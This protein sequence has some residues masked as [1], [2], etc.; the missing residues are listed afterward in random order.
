MSITKK[1]ILSFLI[2]I[3]SFS[4][5]FVASPPLIEVQAQD[6]I[7]TQEGMSEIRSTYGGKNPDDIRIIAVKMIILVL[8]FLGILVLVLILFAGFQWMTSAGNEEKI[9]K[10]KKLLINALI[11]L[12]IILVSWTIARYV[13]V[14]F[15]RVTSNA[16]DYTNYVL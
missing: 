5:F 2:I 1:K 4:V 8:Q 12:V 16:V 11:G 15:G 6:L 7:T 14:M 9:G 10:A 3:F 13:L